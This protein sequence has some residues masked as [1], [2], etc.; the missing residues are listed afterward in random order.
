MEQERCRTV[1][2]TIVAFLTE[3]VKGRPLK[4]WLGIALG[5]GS[6]NSQT[7]AAHDAEGS[8]EI[9]V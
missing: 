4:G 9:E 1:A 8:G 6:W 5:S 7:K 3:P 2:D